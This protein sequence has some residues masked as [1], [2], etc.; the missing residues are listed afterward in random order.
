VQVINAGI[1]SFHLKHNLHRFAG[2]I[3]PLQPDMIISYHG[4]NGLHFLDETIPDSA[5]E[6]RPRPLKL[7]A[8]AEYRLRVIR[9]ARVQ[10]KELTGDPMESDY[11]AA[12]RQLIQA[13][14]SNDVRLVLANFAMAA[15]RASEPDLIEFYRMAFPIAY[16]QIQANEVHS[17]IVER[18]AEQ[19]PDVHFVDTHDGLDGVHEKFID[20]IH[21][22]QVGRQQLA[23]NVFAGIRTVLEQELAAQKATAR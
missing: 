10:E 1:A 11:A 7:L 6:F 15:N 8:D 14:D 2:D 9:Y 23:E 13:A 19:H 4:F 5:P 18:L 21:F 3:L 12:Y 16:W 22:T 20:L 17:F